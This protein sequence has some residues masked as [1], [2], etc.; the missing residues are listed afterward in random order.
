MVFDPRPLHVRFWSRVHPIGNCWIWMGGKND[1]GYG[2]I[3]DKHVRYYVHRL[4]HEWFRGP[5]PDGHEIDH[6]C[7]NPACVRPSHLEAVTRRE[8]QRRGFGFAGIKARKTACV[9]GHAFTA[10]N[11]YIR[12]DDGNRQCRE[13]KRKRDRAY[14]LRT[15][16]PEWAE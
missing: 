9:H 3:V 1:K 6:L 13:C 16:H 7:R 4:S 5:I 15:R 8:N 10:E 11:T 2:Q 12:P 14:K